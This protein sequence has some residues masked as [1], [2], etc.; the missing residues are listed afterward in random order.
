MNKSGYEFLECVSMSTEDLD[1]FE[2]LAGSYAVV[3]F[4]DR[5]LIC[6]NTWRNQWE[7]PAGRREVN[8]TPKE[9]AMRELYEETGQV[10]HNMSLKGILKV[11]KPDGHIKMNP[12]YFGEL[13]Y[14]LPFRINDETD[15]IMFWDLTEDVGYVDE[16]DIA[17]L[18]WC[19]PFKLT[20]NISEQE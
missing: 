16:I 13:E 15:K 17:V 11:R 1:H 8:E 6:F 2:P 4:Q 9:C 12:I 19:K 3:T 10:V 18:N 20:S 14:V 7:I 5:Y